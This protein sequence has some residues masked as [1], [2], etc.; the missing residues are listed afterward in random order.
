MSFITGLEYLFPGTITM[1]KLALLFL[2]A[3]ISELLTTASAH[4]DKHI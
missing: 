1:T 4:V 2:D 3:V